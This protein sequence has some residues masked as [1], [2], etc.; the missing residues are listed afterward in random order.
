MGEGRYGH[1]SLLARCVIKYAFVAFV[2][3]LWYA[4]QY[5]VRQMEHAGVTCSGDL[6][7]TSCA[8]PEDET[9]NLLRPFAFRL[10]LLTI[11]F[12]LETVVFVL[13]FLTINFPLGG[14]VF[15]CCRFTRWSYVP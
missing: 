11:H 13:V 4:W 2:L 8:T 10:R 7:F 5:D 3:C 12:W 9:A 15:P 1:G 6:Q 14:V